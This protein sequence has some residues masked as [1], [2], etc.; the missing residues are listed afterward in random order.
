MTQEDPGP[1]GQD[2]PEP[3]RPPGRASRFRR[4]GYRVRTQIAA[5]VIVLVALAG[6]AVALR[7]DRS[8]S[9]GVT[10]GVGSS[11]L[12][13]LMSNLYAGALRA[14][15][16]KVTLEPVADGPLDA[17]SALR[18]G[19]VDLAPVYTGDGLIALVPGAPQ[20]SAVD[21]HHALSETVGKLGLSLLAASPGQFG[22][23]VVVTADTSRKYQLTDLG[24]LHRVAATMTFG[25]TPAFAQRSGGAAALAR[26]SEA[27]FQTVKP[28]A[29]SDAAAVTALTSGS[30]GA[31]AVVA[32]EPAIIRDG[33]VTLNDGQA[34]FI[35]Q[36]VAALVRAGRLNP[37]GV[38]AC[39]ALAAN[40]TTVAVASLLSH[41]ANAADPSQVAA[42]WLASIGLKA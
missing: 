38:E 10:V 3:A 27:T 40:L 21:V 34:S 41:S 28:L 29:D 19:R 15:Q 8:G 13:K 11:P 9:A 20:R 42:T 23:S 36:N 33:L 30:V 39:N 22:E 32:T 16:V 1:T 18:S 12:N 14:R 6:M 35:S 26:L 5:G 17:V 37:A 7:G 2:Q 4:N 31:T 24:D 25:E